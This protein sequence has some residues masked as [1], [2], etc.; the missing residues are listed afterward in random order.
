MEASIKDRFR[1][2]KHNFSVKEF[3][4]RV[5]ITLSVL[6]TVSAAAIFLLIYL[7]LKTELKKA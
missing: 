7:P 3:S 1:L 5:I 4:R 6:I 2:K